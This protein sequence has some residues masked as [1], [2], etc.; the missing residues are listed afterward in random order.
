VR[1][2]PQ[3]KRAVDRRTTHLT[4][5]PG[6]LVLARCFARR[7]LAG[8]RPPALQS[9]ALKHWVWFKRPSGTQRQAGE[10][11]RFSGQIRFTRLASSRAF[12]IVLAAGMSQSEFRYDVFL[13][14]SAKDK[15]VVRPHPKA[16]GRRRTAGILHSS[17]FLHPFPCDW[18]QWEAGT[19]RFRDPLNRERRF[20]PLRLDDAPS[21]PSHCIVQQRVARSGGS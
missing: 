3:G 21:T 20:L 10:E 19:F 14:H 6:T 1:P 16:E 13:S 9:S 11:S 4:G 5:W 7:I 15:A 12:G 2:A 17:F 18:A 8:L